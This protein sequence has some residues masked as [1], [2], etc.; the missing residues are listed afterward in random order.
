MPYIEKRRDTLQPI[1]PDVAMTAGELN[2]QITSLL[3]EYLEVHGLQYEKLNAVVGALECAKLELYRR[4][5]A[6]YENN[7]IAANGDVYPPKLGGYNASTS[8]DTK[9][10]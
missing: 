9:R 3:I 5:A 7:K 1:A 8:S 6:P 4:V 2:F 10:G